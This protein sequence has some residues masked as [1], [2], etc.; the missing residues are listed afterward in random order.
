MMFTDSTFFK[1]FSFRLL[2]GDPKTALTGSSNAVISESFARRA[3]PGENPIGKMIPIGDSVRVTVSG[4]MEDIKNSSLPETDIFVNINNIRF[5]NP[6]LASDMYNNAVGCMLFF[7][8][9]GSADLSSRAEDILSYFKEVFWPY[10][11]GL[12]KKVIMIPF[13]QLHFYDKPDAMQTLQQA[14]KKFVLI[15]MS[16]GLLILIFAVT[17]YINLTVAQAGQRAKEMA[18]R[19]LLGSSRTDLFLRLMMESTLLT[20]FSFLIAFLLA[21]AADT[22]ANT[23]LNTTINLREAITPTNILIALAAIVIIGSV[24]GLLPAIVISNSKP[25]DIVRG[26]FRRKTKMVFS[27]VFI[28]FQNVIT[29]MMLAASL[30]MVLQINYMIKA[31]LGFNTVNLLDI[32]AEQF[33]DDSQIVSFGNEIAQLASVRRVGYGQGNPASSWNNTTNEIKSINKTVS[34][35]M[36]GGDT[37]WFDMFGFKILRDNHVASSR[38][39]WFLT[40]QA[41]R[42][43]ELTADADSFQLYGGTDNIYP[44]AG[45]ISD[46]TLGNINRNPENEARIVRLRPMNAANPWSIWNVV[47][48][49]QGDPMTA[50][51][52]IKDIYTRITGGLEFTGKFV[53]QEIEDHF[54]AERRIVKIVMIFCGMAIL[55]SLLGLLAMSTYFIRQRSQEIAVRKVFG[56]TN[57]EALVRLVKAFLSYVGVAFVIAT[58]IV[59]YVMHRWISDYAYRIPLHWWIFAAAGL[60]CLTVAFVTVFFQSYRAATA[61]PIKSIKQE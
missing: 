34:F 61:N 30:T 16:V 23:L 12:W 33:E 56:S 32:T 59:W 36:L 52:Q 48:E 29:I 45:V 51:N 27:K 54:V 17:N 8:A 21:L 14:D 19:R 20:F 3:F 18:T 37:T 57:E 55:L 25:I 39:S 22:E 26:G 43:L 46:F 41:L 7:L 40:E 4:V 5:F 28:T 6:S 2:E 50:Y 60:F 13:T 11:L 35:Q 58:P 9:K 49:V 44:I 24:S 1:V 42:V 31:P 47:A 10:Q 53:D 38:Q 15:L